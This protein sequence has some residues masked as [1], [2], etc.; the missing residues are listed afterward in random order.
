MLTLKDIFEGPGP[1]AA[2]AFRAPRGDARVGA[3]ADSRSRGPKAQTH[4]VIVA[5]PVSVRLARRVRGS[6]N[7]L[8]VVFIRLP[9]CPPPRPKSK[10]SRATGACYTELALSTVFTHTAC[11]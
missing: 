3:A 11:Y 10:V 4:R 8:G 1:D 7:F 2:K 5:A 9:G 6:E